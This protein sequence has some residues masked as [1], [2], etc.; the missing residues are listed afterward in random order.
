V[1]A[2]APPKPGLLA[3]SGLMFGIIA[4]VNLCNYGFHAL[5]SRAL[6]PADYGGLMSLLAVLGI[7][8][9]PSQAIQAVMARTLAVEEVNGRFDRVA[10]VARHLLT[11]MALLGGLLALLLVAFGAKWAEFFQLSSARPFWAVGA[12]GLCVLLLPVGRGLLQGLQRFGALGLNLALEALLRL[13]VGAALFALGAGIFGGLLA[14]ALAM[15]VALV[16][17]GAVLWPQART[18]PRPA[19]GVDW[20]AL[21]R[22][23][24]PV[25]LAFGAFAA[26]SSL[27]VIL[28]KHFFPPVAA[29]HYAAA[30]L[31]GKAFLFLPL[32][33]AQVLFPQASAGHARAE[34][35]QTLVSKSLAL[36]AMS[37]A[38]AAVGVWILTVPIVGL[39][40]GARF[41]NPETLWLVK[42]FGLVISPLALTY[43]LV[44]YN[45]AV[46][47]TAFA[48]LLVAD[49]PLLLLGLGTF[50]A[51][52]GQV[53]W[54]L[55]ANHWL[56]G[57]AGYALT[58]GGRHA[59]VRTAA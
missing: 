1:I 56:L 11:R 45:L 37:L 16:L 32:A 5:A 10:A 6:G 9:V 31:V 51:D 52:L 7:I 23:G 34:E 17:A 19:P 49:I 3:A 46:Q 38:L 26:L 42:V 8:A 33:V 22:Y 24:A 58:R 59:R 14:G 27:D 44:Q 21:Y 30:A 53:L 25:V 29:G 57:I 43:L 39:L 15:A 35:T 41:L 4:A 28:V 55:G 20:K 48:W 50:H 47:R 13:I 2:V 36:C 18:W 40:F 54:V 12:G